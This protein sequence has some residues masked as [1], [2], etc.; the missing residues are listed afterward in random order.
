MMKYSIDLSI[1]SS[2]TEAFGNATGEIEL[3]S[4]PV[5]G[6]LVDLV[7]GRRVKITSLASDFEGWGGSEVGL[8]DIVL[9]SKEAAREFAR[10]LESELDFFVVP[11][12][13]E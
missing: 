2:P 6:Q 8:D 10:R 4:P 1:F 3:S 9:E 11:Y 5:L 7:D 12:H 13:E